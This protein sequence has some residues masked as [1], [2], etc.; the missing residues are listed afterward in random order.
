[1]KFKL[2]WEFLSFQRANHCNAIIFCPPRFFMR[3]FVILYWN[4]YISFLFSDFSKIRKGSASDIGSISSLTPSVIHSPTKGQ[5][6]SPT[7]TPLN[8]PEHS[9][10]HSPTRKNSPP[11]LEDNPGYVLGFFARYALPKYCLGGWKCRLCY[12]LT[13]FLLIMDPLAD[14]SNLYW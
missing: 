14:S 9:R 12:F 10:P 1:M 2:G 3:V 13:S 11:T 8:S 7:G 5:S 4:F 6:F